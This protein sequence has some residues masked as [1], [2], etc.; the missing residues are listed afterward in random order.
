MLK[1]VGILISVSLAVATATTTQTSLP[2]S[3]SYASRTVI[4]EKEAAEKAIEAFDI[5]QKDEMWAARIAVQEEKD[6]INEALKALEKIKDPLV[7]DRRLMAI[8][9]NLPVS[10]PD[11]PILSSVV[12]TYDGALWIIQAVER[13]DYKAARRAINIY[14][15]YFR[16]RDEALPAS[17]NVKN[18]VVNEGNQHA[19]ANAWMLIALTRYLNYKE[20]IT[21]EDMPVFDFA[22]D[23]AKYLMSLRNADDTEAY[24]AV[25]TNKGSHYYST[26]HNISARAALKMLNELIACKAAKPSG[27]VDSVFAQLLTKLEIA[28]NDI[29]E[30]LLR[31]MMVRVHDQTGVNIEFIVPLLRI[32]YDNRLFG[33]T[34]Y[35]AKSYYLRRGYS[36]ENGWDDTFAT[37]L[38]LWLALSMDES[39][40]AAFRGRMEKALKE[41]IDNTQHS[42]QSHDR[43]NELLDHLSSMNR[44]D[45]VR[46]A[47]YYARVN[48]EVELSNGRK[49]S[50]R[51]LDFTDEKGRIACGRGGQP[52]T[53]I[54]TIVGR[55]KGK[56][57]ES[58]EMGW[59]EG[60]SFG[61]LALRRE[62][63]AGDAKAYLLVVEGLRED[64]ALP[65]ATLHGEK[66]GHGWDTPRGNK[67]LASTVWYDL[68][69]NN[70][71]PMKLEKQNEFKTDVDMEAFRYAF[72][73]QTHLEHIRKYIE[74]TLEGLQEHMDELEAVEDPRGKLLLF[75]LALSYMYLSSDVGRGDRQAFFTPELGGLFGDLAVIG[76]THEAVRKGDVYGPLA[77]YVALD[78]LMELG[79][80]HISKKAQEK[81]AVVYLPSEKDKGFDLKILPF[82]GKDGW[83]TKPVV[84]EWFKLELFNT[85]GLGQE[86]VLFAMGGE[87]KLTSKYDL[88]GLFQKLFKREYEA[89]V[90]P[91][92]AM[93]FAYVEAVYDS[94]PDSAYFLSR[95]GE[96]KYILRYNYKSDQLSVLAKQRIFVPGTEQFLN[97][98]NAYMPDGMLVPVA[99]LASLNQSATYLEGIFLNYG[100]KIDVNTGAV[101][102]IQSTDDLGYMIGVQDE[103][104]PAVYFEVLSGKLIVPGVKGALLDAALRKG[105]SIRQTINGKTLE[106]KQVPVARITGTSTYY[107]F[108]DSALDK[109]PVVVLKK[110]YTIGVGR[111]SN[112]LKK[113]T[114][115]TFQKPFAFEVELGGKKR[116]IP[117]VIEYNETEHE[118]D[119]YRFKTENGE[120]KQTG[121]P[122]ITW[123]EKR[124][125]DENTPYWTNWVIDY[126]AR[127]A[128]AVMVPRYAQFPVFD[129]K[130]QEF[131]KE[132]TTVSTKGNW[133]AFDYKVS[134]GWPANTEDAL[135]SRGAWTETF[136]LSLGTLLNWTHRWAPKLRFDG[137]G[138]LVGASADREVSELFAARHLSKQP[139]TSVPF[140]S[141]EGFLKVTK[142]GWPQTESATSDRRS[143]T[144]AQR[145]ALN[146][147]GLLHFV[148]GNTRP[149]SEHEA[150]RAVW[151]GNVIPEVNQRLKPYRIHYT[152][153]ENDLGL[154]INGRQID[155]N[156]TAAEALVVLGRDEVGFVQPGVLFLQQR[157]AA[158]HGVATIYD[159]AQGAK[160][161]TEAELVEMLK[162]GNVAARPVKNVESA[163]QSHA[164]AIVNYKGYAGR[165]SMGLQGLA[166]MQNLERTEYAQPY[167]K[168][169]GNFRM[170]TKT[171]IAQGLVSGEVVSI[172]HAG[173]WVLAVP[174]AEGMAQPRL[175]YKRKRYA[176]IGI[177][178]IAIQESIDAADG[179]GFISGTPDLQTGDLATEITPE[180]LRRLRDGDWSYK[181][182]HYGLTS[183]QET[184]DGEEVRVMRAHGLK[185][186]KGNDTVIELT[187]KGYALLKEMTRNHV[188]VE[189]PGGSRYYDLAEFREIAI[190]ASIEADFTG[191]KARDS[192][193]REKFRILVQPT[194]KRIYEVVIYVDNN[195]WLIKEVFT[196]ELDAASNDLVPYAKIQERGRLKLPDETDVIVLE[197]RA[198][199]GRETGSVLSLFGV[200]PENGNGWVAGTRRVEFS[201]C[202]FINDDVDLSKEFLLKIA[203]NKHPS[204]SYI[205]VIEAGQFIPQRLVSLSSEISFASVP[206]HTVLSELTETIAIDQRFVVTP[207]LGDL[208]W[209]KRIAVNERGGELSANYQAFVN[210]HATDTEPVIEIDAYGNCDVKRIMHDGTILSVRYFL[211][212]GDHVPSAVSLS[213]KN[214]RTVIDLDKKSLLVE[215]RDEH[216]GFL[217]KR[218]FLREDRFFDY[219]YNEMLDNLDEIEALSVERIEHLEYQSTNISPV[220]LKARNVAASTQMFHRLHKDG[221]NDILTETTQLTAFHED[222]EYLENGITYHGLV[223]TENH[224]VFY[225]DDLGEDENFRL[226]CRV[227]RDFAGNLRMQFFMVGDSYD[228]GVYVYDFDSNAMGRKSITLTND[229]GLW[230]ASEAASYQES[231]YSGLAGKASGQRPGHA[232]PFEVSRFGKCIGVN[233][234]TDA[235]PVGY[236]TVHDQ[237][238]EILSGAE[239]IASRYVIIKTGDGRL[240]TR[241]D[242][243]SLDRNAQRI[244]DPKYI[245]FMLEQ[246]EVLSAQEVGPLQFGYALNSYT[247]NYSGSIDISSY[248][249]D[250]WNR[251]NCVAARKIESVYA[252]R[253]NKR[254]IVYYSIEDTR[255]GRQTLRAGLYDLLGG[256]PIAEVYSR[257]VSTY[258][259]DPKTIKTVYYKTHPL[260]PVLNYT[261]ISKPIIKNGLHIIE[262][263]F[264]EKT[265][266]NVSGDIIEVGRSS[267]FVQEHGQGFLRGLVVSQVE[268]LNLFTGLFEGDL[269][270]F[271]LQTGNPARIPLSYRSRSIHGFT[272]SSKE[273]IW[274]VKYLLPWLFSAVALIPFI[275]LV[276]GRIVRSREKKRRAVQGVPLWTR[277]LS[278]TMN[279]RVVLN[280][281][282]LLTINEKNEV[283]LAD[284]MAAQEGYSGVLPNYFYGSDG[285]IE[286]RFSGQLRV[287][288]NLV[289][290]W[291]HAN[292][293]IKPDDML[294]DHPW[295]NGLDAYITIWSYIVRFWIKEGGR[296]S[297]H[298]WSRLEDYVGEFVDRF[299]QLLIQYKKALSQRE[300]VDEINRKLLA[301]FNERGLCAR[302]APL[303]FNDKARESHDRI[304]LRRIV[305]SFTQGLIDTSDIL[306]E[307]FEADTGISVK[308]END[309]KTIAGA[310]EAHCTVRD[311]KGGNLLKDIDFPNGGFLEK[312][313][314][315][316]SRYMLTEDE[317]FS[318]EQ[319]IAQIQHMLRDHEAFLKR[320]GSNN[321]Q[322]HPCVLIAARNVKD[323]FPIIVTALIAI[324]VFAGGQSLFAHISGAMA[325]AGSFFPFFPGGL[326]GICLAAIVLGVGACS[327]GN[328]QLRARYINEYS[329]KVR[330]QGIYKP[331]VWRTAGNALRACGFIGL[332]GLLFYEAFSVNVVTAKLLFLIV[333]GFCLLETAGFVSPPLLSF[334]GARFDLKSNI[335]SPARGGS[336]SGT[337]LKMIWRPTVTSGKTTLDMVMAAVFYYITFVTFALTAICLLLNVY[338]LYF[339][340]NL[341]SGNI[342]SVCIASFIVSIALYLTQFGIGQAAVIV[343]TF[344]RKFPVV[345][346]G[347]V[348][349]FI[350]GWALVFVPGA[351]TPVG[352]GFAA[353]PFAAIAFYNNRIN[354]FFKR[355]GS[356]NTAFPQTA[357]DG[358]RTIGHIFFGGQS[359]ASEVFFNDLERVLGR[360][361]EAYDVMK[362][363]LDSK[364]VTLLGSEDLDRSDL[365]DMFRLLLE[366][367]RLAE[368]TL[369]HP[370]QIQ[371]PG[372][373]S[374]FSDEVKQKL[375][376]ANL[377]IHAANKKEAQDLRRAWDIR[378]WMYSHCIN[379]GSQDS[380]INL[381]EMILAYRKES[382][383][384]DVILY[385]GHNKYNDTSELPSKTN[386]KAITEVGQRIK[387]CKMLDAI[388]EVKAVVCYSWTPFSCKSAGM[389]EMDLVP[390]TEHLKKLLIV[391]RN[392]C[393]NNLDTFIS[394]LKSAASDQNMVL[395][396]PGRGTTKTLTRMGQASQLIEEGHRMYLQGLEFFG[397]R[398]G[399]CIGTGWG[400]IISLYG[401]EMLDQYADPDAVLRPLTSAF[402]NQDGYAKSFGLQVFSAHALGVSEDIWAVQQQT[403]QAIALGR[404]PNYGLSRALWHKKRETYSVWAWVPAMP[405]WSG[406]ALQKVFDKTM[407]SVFELGPLSMFAKSIRTQGSRYFLT[408]AFSFIFILTMPFAIILGVSPFAGTVALLLVFGILFNQILAGHS[409]ILYIDQAGYNRW[410]ALISGV[411][412]FVAYCMFPA[413][414]STWVFVAFIIGGVAEGFLKW[415]VTRPRDLI[416]FPSL[417]VIQMI[418]QI[419]RQTCEFAISGR[420]DTNFYQVSA[421]ADFEKDFYKITDKI[422]E[423]REN[424]KQKR[425]CLKKEKARKLTIKE[426]LEEDLKHWF[427]IHFVKDLFGYVFNTMI[428]PISM[429]GVFIFVSSLWALTY[430]VSLKDVCLLY[431]T[432]TFSIGVTV[433]PFVMTVQRGR[434]LGYFNKLFAGFGATAGIA[435]SMFIPK[436]E[437]MNPYIVLAAVCVLIAGFVTTVSVNPFSRDKNGERLRDGWITDAL[438]SFLMRSGFARWAFSAF[439]MPQ[440]LMGNYQQINDKKNTVAVSEILKK[441][442]LFAQV[443]RENHGYRQQTH[444]AVLMF[445]RGFAVGFFASIPFFYVPIF[446]MFHMEVDGIIIGIQTS[447][448]L[449]FIVTVVAA[450][451]CLWVVT[452]LK[453]K[454]ETKLLIRRRK[455]S[456]SVLGHHLDEMSAFD[457]SR[458]YALFADIKTFIDQESLRYAAEYMDKVE[459]ILKNPEFTR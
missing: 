205:G 96:N 428:S 70:V 247:Y 447:T 363:N 211:Y 281:L 306:P 286:G 80:L 216:A 302:D 458:I 147:F 17:V 336:V 407:Q 265:N 159:P 252:D 225:N 294:G 385:L 190:K 54:E 44:K 435:L 171:Q 284:R 140:F 245:T 267:E 37:D 293:G 347:V 255:Q 412:V 30:Y 448:F 79:N 173:K 250:E 118:N 432:L 355:S 114:T 169:S 213:Q 378:R 357:G 401:G 380:A 345:F 371:H 369:Y 219:S 203:N 204:Q 89:V 277:E 456:L 127:L 224:T 322:D 449:I 410:F 290:E 431:L 408:V 129:I 364:A 214:K 152:E 434:S 33:F 28:V 413:I 151:L 15:S 326:Y 253:I 457:Q 124:D 191:M 29:E 222:W 45:L 99:G 166:I 389:L 459:T 83:D 48:V 338:Q 137:Q 280:T 353:L 441:E 39:E 421:V 256:W 399:E 310:V 350:V 172:R 177:P 139:I 128:K 331:F 320:E 154:V 352:V 400:N 381:V 327:F 404:T 318:Y 304:R 307:S 330:S 25:A 362:N 358:H 93:R 76:V 275:G 305:S 433:G 110:D 98:Y 183:I 202:E 71:N 295:L 372:E 346:L 210:N 349:A 198:W 334:L 94:A 85:F 251:S 57:E 9:N 196:Y 209:I 411:T 454:R 270:A 187:D 13:G 264:L 354:A 123:E 273:A 356:K 244:G 292:E 235:I 444:R 126:K 392:A 55:G 67:S 16:E 194:G 102:V 106:I 2:L 344:I 8:R 40:F 14:N 64:G 112:T 259:R 386:V 58:K 439:F 324:N 150:H 440:D 23:L 394:D 234:D 393:C 18:G 175:M 333:S 206:H 158:L 426:Y 22:I 165:L 343:A 164:Y 230:T 453:R 359:L 424:L 5:R 303:T 283:V 108:D 176:L 342:I 3:E 36:E 88:V 179:F 321:I 84:N 429:V 382:I 375:V 231:V 260:Y 192:L 135:Q 377:M 311:L 180:I 373:R 19:G 141:E 107:V 227:F 74:T 182:K 46:Q 120:I 221:T 197:K 388:S 62:G 360:Y 291:V 391:D 288:A 218:E 271:D 365:E 34:V 53:A 339:I 43:V 258:K 69:K 200:V 341:V 142:G 115:V 415:M 406:G 145:S 7:D 376:S 78:R 228:R 274:D 319:G 289:G 379:G 420:N 12:Y 24:G 237:F 308:R 430:A 368:M 325:S 299:R 155:I 4:E 21:A 195:S 226:Q 366:K 396:I 241:M 297:T 59:L 188:A 455:K 312:L 323:F 402:F 101:E 185:D 77:W 212:S 443:E 26:E 417:L 65:Y 31:S 296:E 50:V 287:L 201:F 246:T 10:Y 160:S 220:L 416:L 73:P 397:G 1:V 437:F 236:S 143:L 261:E 418:G 82:Y 35:Q 383:D 285:P 149:L 130:K 317:V 38:A 136:F 438:R 398:A 56:V 167:T 157:I 134:F 233:V 272:E 63:E 361:L 279:E 240:A 97:D 332:A 109:L 278:D 170:A 223:E 423:L 60:T 125:W 340:G 174:Y 436:I 11:D 266:L 257:I 42:T 104:A 425:N 313:V 217:N 178:R 351:D 335:F 92:E 427:T 387:L 249:E 144:S 113:G 72:D 51:L 409:L 181:G 337:A 105:G 116:M 100:V 148:S 446:K 119:P 146:G 193:G 243:Y 442:A 121:P 156:D 41:Q 215:H 52:A 254:S 163:K 405:R 229:A 162:T 117:A 47:E 238:E 298:V 315:V 153:N 316:M 138:H 75:N 262:P 81:G 269:V 301:L 66:T 445:K 242:G 374:E 20:K 208:T 32:G 90:I 395:M 184:F 87:E 122:F 186:K 263:P 86:V 450:I 189:T 49:K 248:L 68:A 422:K 403:Y 232:F 276:S 95:V 348:A 282:G 161:F 168:G 111:Y 419:I 370:L 451:T 27:N 131:T 390:G 207:D 133:D 61:A 300:S 314:R 268:K 414:T 91:S 239:N 384:K 132:E 6:T 328:R 103:G 309:S 329:F 199:N 452:D 367:E